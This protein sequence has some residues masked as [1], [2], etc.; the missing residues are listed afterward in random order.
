MNFFNNDIKKIERNIY[1]K[2]IT[3]G[4][5]IDDYEI[6]GQIVYYPLIITKEN[7]EKLKHI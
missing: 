6:R 4:K 3:Q 1:R 5:S 7:M 2:I